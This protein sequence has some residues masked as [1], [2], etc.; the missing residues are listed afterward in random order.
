MNVATSY[1]RQENIPVAVGLALCGVVV[2]TPVFAAGKLADGALPAL[3]LVWL[4]FLGGAMTIGT[5]AVWKGR[6]ESGWYSPQWRLHLLRA[7]LAIGGLCSFIVAGT[8]LPVADVAAIG[9]TKG[10]FAIVLAGLLLRETILAR[11]WIAGFLCALGAY[12]VVRTSTVGANTFEAE[13]IAG[14]AAALL[15]AFCV[16]CEGLLIK[17]LARR[18]STLIVLGY[19]NTFAALALTLPVAWFALSDGINWHM[20]MLFL[21][22]GPFAIIGQSFNIQAYRRADAATLAPV[23]YTWVLCAAV[24]GYLVFG[25]VPAIEAAFGAVLI[26]LGGIVLAF[27]SDLRARFNRGRIGCP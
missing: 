11:H 7:A 25:E 18:E 6:P 5:Y 15:G 9:L 13:A 27:G 26:I 14:I 4:R 12:L 17:V 21:L 16:A 1:H 8:V 2:F 20:A 24:F 3:V 22:L 10:I 23:G 19:V